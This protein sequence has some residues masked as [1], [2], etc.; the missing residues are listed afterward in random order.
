MLNSIADGLLVLAA[1]IAYQVPSGRILAL[2]RRIEFVTLMRAVM[3]KP[4][5]RIMMA[6]KIKSLDKMPITVMTKT[7]EYDARAINITR[8]NRAFREKARGELDCVAGYI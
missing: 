8:T 3:A 2:I 5:R 1:Y 7:V 4:A 6:T